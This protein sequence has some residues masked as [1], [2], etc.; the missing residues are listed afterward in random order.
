MHVI[1]ISFG[2]FNALVIVQA[3]YRVGEWSQV[4]LLQAQRNSEFLTWNE[5]LQS[6]FETFFFKIWFD[7]KFYRKV[8][9]KMT[10]IWS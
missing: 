4:P 5:T 10:Y 2:I 6:E 7:L 9:I 3:S 8:G 1:Q